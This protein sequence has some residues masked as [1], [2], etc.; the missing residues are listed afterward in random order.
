[1]KPFSSHWI[2][3][4]FKSSCHI[5]TVFTLAF[6]GMSMGPD[7]LTKT[8]H[9]TFK[10][11]GVNNYSAKKYGEFTLWIHSVNNHM[12]L[13]KYIN[14]HK[15]HQESQLLQHASHITKILIYDFTQIFKNFDHERCNLICEWQII[16]C[17]FEP[18]PDLS[19]TATSLQYDC[20]FY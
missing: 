13:K 1:M 16:N 15:I 7:N 14:T 10:F 3:I 5:V 18:L 11:E 2:K 12:L 20:S 6:F 17:Y 9:I 19:M 4:K 8:V